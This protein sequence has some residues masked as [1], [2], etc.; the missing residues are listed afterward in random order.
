LRAL[1]EILSRQPPPWAIFSGPLA[2]KQLRL[3]SVNPF[4]R[5]LRTAQG[6]YELQMFT[7]AVAQLDTMPLSAQLRGDVL[8]M[9]VLILMQDK[10]WGE[11]LSSCEKLCAVAPDTPTGF[12]HMAYCL[13]ELGR[14]Q[15][16]KDVLLEGPAALNRDAT[17]HYNMACY[18]CALGN[19][20]TARVYL[21]TSLSLD[22]KLRDY[23]ITDPDLKP[24]Q[25]WLE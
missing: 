22:G 3:Y 20:D 8:E 16:A 2:R 19:I 25:P 14:T 17:Y 24:L 5:I 1:H 23:A 4:D 10:R 9:R 15:H 6:Y 12:I 7:D 21:E 18:E 11:A 13:H